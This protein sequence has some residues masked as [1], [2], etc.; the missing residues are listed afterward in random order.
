[1]IRYS[2][3]V[4]HFNKGLATLE[5]KLTPREFEELFSAHSESSLIPKNT[6]R[7]Y[8][9]ALDFWFSECQ[10]LYSD[11]VQESDFDYIR[12]A[13]WV[14]L[15]RGEGSADEKTLLICLSTL[16]TRQLVLPTPVFLSYVDASKYDVLLLAEPSGDGYEHGSPG[17]GHDHRA[18]LDW[19]ASHP[20]ITS[21]R[22]IRTVGSSAGGHFAIM[23]ASKLGA[24]LALSLG[25][26][27]HKERY[28][29]KIIG[30]LFSLL[31][32]RK[33]GSEF[34]LVLA[35]SAKVS[36][37]RIYA[38]VVSRIFGG[39]MFSVE[40]SKGKFEHVIL[41]EMSELKQL[42]KFLDHTLFFDIHSGALPENRVMQF[43]EASIAKME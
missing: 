35:Y 6:D 20:T 34:T 11:E 39:S 3:T 32:A 12:L 5:S 10:K 25:G 22:A 2:R 31:K 9:K 17:I 26:R 30:R 27:F 38:K 40:A 18:I 43:P 21:Y 8:D 36:R 14:A 24:E 13:P 16:G 1:M 41:D 42:K 33:S 19:M 4:S 23:V 37:D 28:P 15:Y 29:L 7:K